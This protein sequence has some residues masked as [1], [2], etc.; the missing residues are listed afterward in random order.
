MS[1]LEGFQCALLAFLQSTS[2]NAWLYALFLFIYSA[3][4]AIFLPVPVEF[5]L[6]FAGNVQWW[7]KPI[8]L[9]LGKMV[10]AIGIFFLGIRIEFRIREWAEAHRLVEWALNGVFFFVK[11]TRWV[12]LLILLSI[13][14]MPD[15]APIYVYSIFNRQGQAV[16]PRAFL[17]VN[18]AAGFIRASIFQFL[19]ARGSACPG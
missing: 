14:F 3:L 7:Q 9:G 6:F 4:A 13:P 17:I 11:Y 5:G 1:L 12:G 10:G 8:V 15:S 19:L 16:S 2:T 18:F